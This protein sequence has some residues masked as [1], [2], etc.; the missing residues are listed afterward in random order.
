[1]GRVARPPKHGGGRPDDNLEQPPLA[2]LREEP[3]KINFDEYCEDPDTGIGNVRVEFDGEPGELAN[4]LRAIF[5]AY[6]KL[7][8][9]E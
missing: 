5:G 1:M 2:Q 3:G 6:R 4:E 8:T 9:E 7:E